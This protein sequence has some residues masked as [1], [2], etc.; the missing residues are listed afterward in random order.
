MFLPSGSRSRARVFFG[1]NFKKLP[2]P[3]E[4]SMTRL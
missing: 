4:G 3:A 1:K 2:E